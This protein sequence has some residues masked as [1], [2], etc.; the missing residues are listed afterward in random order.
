MRHPYMQGRVLRARETNAVSG[1]PPRSGSSKKSA[2]AHDD[3]KTQLGA[4]RVTWTEPEWRA[5]VAK[6]IEIQEQEPNLS[7]YQAADRAQAHALLTTRQRPFY[8][9]AGNPQSRLREGLTF[10]FAQ[11]RAE[12][13]SKAQETTVDASAVIDAPEEA[14]AASEPE[15]TALE[16]DDAAPSSSEPPAPVEHHAERKTHVRWDDDDKL[17]I[18]R[19]SLELMRGFDGMK[20]LE[21]IRKAMQYELT[22]DKQRTIAT[23]GDVKWIDQLWKQVQDTE[24]AEALAREQAQAREEDARRLERERQEQAVRDAH[25]AHERAEAERIAAEKAAAREQSIDEAVNER[26]AAMSFEG[27]V[28]MFANKVAR[29]VINEI[30]ASLYADIEEQI[31]GLVSAAR[32]G[33]TP[34]A[35]PSEQIVIKRPA[36]KPKVLICGLL[37]QQI[38][39]I[40]HAYGD[41]LDVDFAKHREEG[42][43]KLKDKGA[44]DVVLIMDEWGGARFKREAKA[45]GIAYVPINGTVSALKKWLDAYVSSANGAQ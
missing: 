16:L 8:S 15:Q 6:A 27:I 11:M 12:L 37:N 33:F 40:K 7:D 38:A 39:E 45:A 5:V 13:A 23:F 3:I 36:H 17:K 31:E 10:Y 44:R 9:A 2:A 30:G 18:A 35:A 22:D 41:V 24:Q 42:G 28:R 19:K 43:V 4:L 21:A 29:T 34:G 1:T 32:A 26:L 14:K 20:P 25:E